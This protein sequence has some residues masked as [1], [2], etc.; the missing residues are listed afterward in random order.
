MKA[1][2]DASG[3]KDIAQLKAAI[4]SAA[5]IKAED[6]A[7]YEATL[8]E[9][10]LEADRVVKVAAM[11]AAVKSKDIEMVK[12]AIKDAQAAGVDAAEISKA[13]EGLKALELEALQKKMTV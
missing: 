2:A 8:K 3:A 10:E 5:G 9:L 6:L 7:P 13:E 11:D 4:A 1:L 12:G